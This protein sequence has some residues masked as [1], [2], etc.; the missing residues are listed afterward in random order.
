MIL[1]RISL[2]VYVLFAGLSVAAFAQKQDSVK[3]TR[4]GGDEPLCRGQ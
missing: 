2:I 1:K 3:V 4:G